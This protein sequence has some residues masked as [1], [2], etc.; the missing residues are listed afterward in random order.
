MGFSGR[1]SNQELHKTRG[2]AWTNVAAAR[3]I[4]C[5]PDHMKEPEDCEVGGLF[6]A[7]VVVADRL[8]D[9]CEMNEREN[10]EACEVLAERGR[11]Q[12]EAAQLREENARL[13]EE[14]ARLRQA[15]AVKAA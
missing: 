9:Q 3:T 13:Q 6:E 10:I 2:M 8:D 15:A 14:V 4:L 12:N 7:L 1:D 5:N 11:L